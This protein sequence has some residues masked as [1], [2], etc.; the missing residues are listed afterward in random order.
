MNYLKLAQEANKLDKSYFLD[1]YSRLGTI[2]GKGQNAF[3]ESLF[4]VIE[5]SDV[6]SEHQ[7][8]TM[9]IVEL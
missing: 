6:K 5:K 8:I 7:G 4:S 1:E 9:K 3:E 2:E